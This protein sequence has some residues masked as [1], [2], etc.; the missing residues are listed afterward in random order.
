[1]SKILIA[2]IATATLSVA[3][4]GLAS[5]PASAETVPAAEISQQLTSANAMKVL[6][7]LKES[8]EL[9]SGYGRAK[10]GAWATKKGCNTRVI[11][12]K[13]ESRGP[14]G[15]P[16]CTVISG[17]WVSPYDDEAVTA[18]SSLAIDHMVP[19]PEAWGSGASKWNK[20][21]RKA[22]T[23]DLG[24]AGTLI[25]VTKSVHRSK[26]DRDPAQW[27]PPNENY[28]CTYAKTW[29]ATKYRWKL[30]VD[31]REKSALTTILKND[32]A[33]KRVALPPRAKVKLRG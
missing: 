25:A 8:G 7:A 5:V 1:M 23:N 24:Y 29:I 2:S 20:A 9:G 6:N 33:S 3:T 27:M 17:D 21:T 12:L 16:T 10:F 31:A 13:I 22:F 32:C 15:A 18:P 19:L 30:S 26:G 4:L 14:E 11:V 28:R